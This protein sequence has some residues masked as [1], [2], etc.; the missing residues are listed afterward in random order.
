MEK[1]K[2]DR[3]QNKLLN[4]FI[5]MKKG[6]RDLNIESTKASVWPSVCIYLKFT[7]LYITKN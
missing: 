7:L 1:I 5:Y 4:I 3:Q 2:S 6:H